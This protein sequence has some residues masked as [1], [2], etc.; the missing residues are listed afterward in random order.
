[1]APSAFEMNK[2]ITYI[3]V[4]KPFSLKATALGHGWHECSPVSWCEA[5]ECLQTVER[6]G[7]MPVRL[8]LTQVSGRGHSVR[9]QVMVEADDVGAS[10]VTLMRHRA[11]TMLRV[12]LD[13]KEFFDLAAGHPK[14]GPIVEIG[15][16]RILRCPS[17]TENIIKTLCA[18]NVNWTQAVKMINRIGQLGPCL[19]HFRSLNAW[20]T[21]AE[22]IAAGKD[23]LV[24]V[25]RVG[26]RADSILAFC[27][28]V[29]N[30]SFDAEGLDELARKASTEELFR[31]LVSIKGIGPASA[32]FLLGLLGRF[33]RISVD[34]WTIT[35]VA[36]TYMKGR[37][38]TVRQ[39]EKLYERY[40]RWR[41]LV[42]WFE[43]WLT[44]DTARSMRDGRS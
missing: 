2:A 9:V 24:N 4:P 39:V 13:L 15:A 29:Q 26:Y 17:M 22:I 42:W 40:G 35:Y 25:V 23:Y 21:P 27:R 6:I 31:R 10:V 19:K 33:D 20:P 7:N 5:G 44:W 12:E 18:T 34:S 37:K 32:N 11:A 8:S 16:G 38:P 3:K 30:G 28:S 43:Q 36:R 14:L 41:Q 1:M